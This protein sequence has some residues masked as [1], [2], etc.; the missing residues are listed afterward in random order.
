MIRSAMVPLGAFKPLGSVLMVGSL[1]ACTAE[2]DSRSP[3]SWILA[4]GGTLGSIYDPNDNGVVLLLAPDQ[5][6]SCTNLLTQWLEWRATN[7]DRFHL[8][9]SR[10]PL[11][12]EKARLAPLPISGTL[13]DLLD[14]TQLPVE[15]VFSGSEL[16]Y[17]SPVLFGVAT[18]TLLAELRDATLEEAIRRIATE[19][20]RAD[21]VAPV[22]E[23]QPAYRH[24]QHRSAHASPARYASSLGARKR[25]ASIPSTLERGD[26]WT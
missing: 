24:R 17:R 9:L 23:R 21:S 2:P 12:W 7:P 3:D 11:H 6:F 20:E 13:R 26:S 14:P 15:L 8:V 22:A 5:C 18:S 19:S 1:S 10:A 16:V 25:Q 4:E